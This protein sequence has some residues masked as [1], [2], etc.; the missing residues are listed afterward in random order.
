MDEVNLEAMYYFK[1]PH[2]TTERALVELGWLC[3]A[4]S[5]SNMAYLL[6]FE[7]RGG[8]LFA[9]QQISYDLEAPGTLN[10]FY[11]DGGALVVLGRTA[12]GSPHCCPK[13]LDEVTFDW[14]GKGFQVRSVQRLFLNEGVRKAG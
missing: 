9:T 2:D 13:S 7:V 5:S 4:G 14:N 12:D 1:G 11:P 10:R 8:D 3:E 6:V